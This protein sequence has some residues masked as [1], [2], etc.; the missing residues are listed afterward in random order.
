MEKR[1]VKRSVIVNAT[2]AEVWKAITDPAMVKQYFFG[3]DVSTDW[4]E[5][6]PI[7]YSG[8]WKGKEYE[9]KGQVLKV[10]KEKRLEHTHWSSLS[11]MEDLPENYF[12]VI[13]ELEE[14]VNDTVLTITQVGLMSANSYEH[15]AQN[16]ET[17][18]QQLKALVEKEVFATQVVS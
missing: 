12:T 15:S 2:A 9:D 11:G 13:Y 1:A 7:I 14:R 10:E 8:M 16:W 18:L 3:T 6:S 5:G 4:K 17:V